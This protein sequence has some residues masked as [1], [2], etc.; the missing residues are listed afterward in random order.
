MPEEAKTATEWT[1][2]ALVDEVRRRLARVDLT[3]AQLVEELN[4]RIGHLDRPE[5]Y[6]VV[7]MIGEAER[8]AMLAYEVC[9]AVK[10]LLELARS[11]GS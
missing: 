11:G 7:E 2:N 10:F 5:C 3:D 4:R 8:D 9:D 1:D 6:R